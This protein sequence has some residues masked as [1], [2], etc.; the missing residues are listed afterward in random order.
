M[1]NQSIMNDTFK[2]RLTVSEK[3]SEGLLRELKRGKQWQLPQQKEYWALNILNSRASKDFE[4]HA[5]G[6]PFPS[7]LNNFNRSSRDSSRDSSTYLYDINRKDKG[8]GKTPERLNE[9]ERPN[10]WN[11]HSLPSVPNLLNSCTNPRIRPILTSKSKAKA[12][13]VWRK[14]EISQ[15]GSATWAS[16]SVGSTNFTTIDTRIAK[17]SS[18]ICRSGENNRRKEK[19]GKY[20]NCEMKADLSVVDRLMILNENR[21]SC[22]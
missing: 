22:I 12:N 10:D 14:H 21:K 6:M 3:T 13:L 7:T 8:T 15:T 5:F 18:V 16:P 9:R 17:T 20:N 4:T 1:S 11:A 19:K 2:Q